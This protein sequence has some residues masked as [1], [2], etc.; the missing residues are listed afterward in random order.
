MF[1][2]A[3]FKVIPGGPFISIL[4]DVAPFLA[5]LLAIGNGFVCLRSGGVVV[6][7][8]AI[9]FILAATVGIG[10][11]MVNVYM[12]WVAPHAR[13]DLIGW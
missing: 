3:S 2:C 11:V 10:L 13:G 8:A 4:H 6:R 12:F 5:G 7:I 9:F 1:G